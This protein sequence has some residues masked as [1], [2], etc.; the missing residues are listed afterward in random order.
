VFCLPGLIGVFFFPASFLHV[1]S[2]FPDLSDYAP[3]ANLGSYI[4]QAMH[5][6]IFAVLNIA[7]Q[8]QFEMCVLGLMKTM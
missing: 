6:Y 8:E 5:D 4:Q 2:A 7:F 1:W 3:P